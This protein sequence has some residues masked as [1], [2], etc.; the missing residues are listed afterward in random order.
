MARVG[1]P[2]LEKES[3]RIL[4]GSGA[5]KLLRFLCERCVVV[6]VAPM[7]ESSPCVEDRLSEEFLL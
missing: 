7:I 5:N 2:W 6:G 3:S 4:V 1:I